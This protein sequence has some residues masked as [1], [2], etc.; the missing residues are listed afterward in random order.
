MLLSSLN[1]LGRSSGV[2][3]DIVLQWVRRAGELGTV[4]PGPAAAQP[5]DLLRVPGTSYHHDVHL[6][7]A[8]RTL[9]YAEFHSGK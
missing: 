4:L 9:P 6:L 3:G 2:G 8:R 5:A 7:P 1:S